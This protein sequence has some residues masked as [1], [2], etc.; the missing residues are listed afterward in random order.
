MGDS[1]PFSHAYAKMQLF[2]CADREVR[3]LEILIGFVFARKH[4]AA[5]RCFVSFNKLQGSDAVGFGLL[6]TISRRLH[7]ICSMEWP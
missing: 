4:V 2:L 1:S 5:L 7:T 3:V 6:L